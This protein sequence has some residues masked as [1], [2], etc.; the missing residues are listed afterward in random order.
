MYVMEQW[1]E[2]FNLR[3]GFLLLWLKGHDRFIIEEVEMSYE[4]RETGN[5]AIKGKGSVLAYVFL[6]KLSHKYEAW[7]ISPK[8]HSL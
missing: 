3:E 6:R 8:R 1:L 7:W 2:Q 5:L 4:L